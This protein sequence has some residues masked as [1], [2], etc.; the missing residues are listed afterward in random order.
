MNLQLMLQMIKMKMKKD[1]R[2]MMRK[3]L[4]NNKTRI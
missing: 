4:I 1:H 2:T 3:D